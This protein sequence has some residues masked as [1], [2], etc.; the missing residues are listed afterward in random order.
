MK[1]FR[2]VH[3]KNPDKVIASEAKQ[4]D[5]SVQTEKRDCSASQNPAFKIASAGL[6]NPGERDFGRNRFTMTGNL[7][8]EIASNPPF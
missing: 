4:S 7:F 5:L 1:K 3:L 2:W 8:F 6:R